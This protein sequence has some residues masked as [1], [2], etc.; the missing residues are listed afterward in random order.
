MRAEEAPNP[1]RE[2]VKDNGPVTVDGHPVFKHQFQ[3]VREHD[4]FHI[5]TGLRHVLPRMGVVHRN[6]ALRD[7]GAFVEILGGKMRR[8][9]DDLPRAHMPA[10][11]GLPRRRRAETNG[12]CL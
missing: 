1:F 6:Y 8:R 10:G 11:T 3:G 9:A 2:S 7:D 12:E 4:R 5:P